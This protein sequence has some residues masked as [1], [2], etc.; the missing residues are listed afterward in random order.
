MMHFKPI[1]NTQLEIG[2][3]G[4]MRDRIIVIR[5][6]HGREVTSIPHTTIVLIGDGVERD[7]RSAFAEKNI[8]REGLN[9]LL[10]TAVSGNSYSK[11]YRRYTAVL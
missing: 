2:S 4:V 1:P 11:L 9:N 8:T 10:D 6:G 7:L 5:N 3:R